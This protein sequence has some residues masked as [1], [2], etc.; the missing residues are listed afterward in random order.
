VAR[1]LIVETDYTQRILDIAERLP[2]VEVCC[3]AARPRPAPPRHADYGWCRS[4]RPSTNNLPRRS[5]WT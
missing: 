1:V 4:M 2:K 3:I 5:E